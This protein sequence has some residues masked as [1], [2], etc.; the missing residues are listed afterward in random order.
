MKR[1]D[2]SCLIMFNHDASC[3]IMNNHEFLLATG[4]VQS[5]GT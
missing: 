4:W 3:R 1:H 5:R 2:L